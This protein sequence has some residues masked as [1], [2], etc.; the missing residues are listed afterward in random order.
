MFLFGII[1]KHDGQ[2]SQ[3]WLVEVVSSVVY[4]DSTRRST[5]LHSEQ[6]FLVTC[7][8]AH[9]R[10]KT[11]LLTT[12]RVGLLKLMLSGG[13]AGLL[14]H[15]V[16]KLE[17]KMV[18]SNSTVTARCQALLD[19]AELKLLFAMPPRR[20]TYASAYSRGQGLFCYFARLLAASL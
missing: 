12:Y 8:S 13:V 20:R 5:H 1:S 4:T 9:A 6:Q 15:M 16:T 10:S 7:G 11:L 17:A 3:C 2:P 19:A 14:N 18:A